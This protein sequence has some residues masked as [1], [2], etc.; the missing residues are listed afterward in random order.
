[1][2][3]NKWFSSAD[4]WLFFKGM[5]MGAAD[6]VPGVSG[7][8]IAFITGIY[9]R[10]LNAL[11]TLHP[12]TLKVLVQDG[13]L[14]FW[15][16]IDGRFLLTL[17]AGILVSIIS[18]AKF[19]H[20]AIDTFPILVWSFFFGLVLASIFYLMRQIH[21]WRW[22]EFL[23]IGIGTVTAITISILRPTEL[24]DTW[25]MMG[26]SG[27]VAICAMILPGISGSFILLLMGMYAVV[28]KALNDL[29]IILLASF[30]VGCVLGLA[31]FSH[32]LSFL[33][34][35]Y[36]SLMLAALTGFLIGSLNVLWPWKEVLETMVNRHGEIVP[37]VQ[38]NV[39]PFYYQQLSHE[40]A[41]I[42]FATL[43][44]VVGFLIVFVLDYVSHQRK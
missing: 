12:F 41:Q 39:S 25:W 10:L 4:L 18:L 22:Q 17:F 32:L 7:G 42:L 9:Q 21:Q 11:K 1:M 44:A 37:V 13:V 40:S 35:R 33:L 27:F 8:T 31:V 43:V 28:I 14:E 3:A 6:V 24:P 26:I 2:N 34:Q 38:V 20:Y 15:R 36:S 5:A 30:G 16:V 23:A 29:D 19:I